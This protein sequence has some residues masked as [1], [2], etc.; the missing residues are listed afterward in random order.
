MQ[1]HIK[2]ILIATVLLVAGAGFPFLMLVGVVKTTFWLSILSYVA[3]IAGL[4]LGMYGVS[5]MVISKRNEREWKDW[6]DL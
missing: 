3:S 6:R 4:M 1:P 2:H 5:A